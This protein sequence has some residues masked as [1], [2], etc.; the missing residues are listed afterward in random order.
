MTAAPQPLVLTTTSTVV[1]VTAGH[2]R[3]EDAVTGRNYALAVRGE[4]GLPVMVANMD[5]ESAEGYAQRFDALLLSGG[6]D[7]DPILFDQSPHPDLGVVDQ[8][9]DA[10]EL[11]LYRAFREAGKP[12]M[13]VCRG[14][15]VIN[16]AQGGSLHQHLPAVPG[17]IQHGQRDPGGRPHHLVELAPGSLLAEAF[18]VDRL[19]VNTYHHQGLDRLGH[20]LRATA[21]A[22]DGLVEGIEGAEGG[23]LMAVQWHPEMSYAAYPEQRAP[24][25]VFLD[26]CRAYL[27]SG[28]RRAVATT[29]V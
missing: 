28:S 13:G 16:V 6:V 8:A 3:R 17:S 24:F 11:A 26:A 2:L 10:F 29:R 27:E 12:I 25:R 1:P 7:I 15:Q 4:G 5:P 20:G 18:G 23:F 19:Q 9:R 22:P 21:V 14:F